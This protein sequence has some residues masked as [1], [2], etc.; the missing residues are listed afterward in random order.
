MTNWRVDPINGNDS[1][2][3]D[4]WTLDLSG[5]DGQTYGTTTFTTATGGLT[6]MADRWI[7][8]ASTLRYIVSVE[9][10]TSCTLDATY[11]SGSGRSFWIGGPFQNCTLASTSA[12][13]GDV[14]RYPKTSDPQE[15]DD[16]T[17]TNFDEDVTIP[18][19]HVQLVEDCEAGW[20]QSTDITVTHAAT[21]KVCGTN[22]LRIAPATGFTTGKMAY[23]DFGV[24]NEL[25]LSSFQGLSLFFGAANYANWTGGIVKI[26]LCS[27]ATGDTVVDEIDI[28]LYGLYYNSTNSRGYVNGMKT[29]GG[30]LG[31]SIRSIAI[32]ATTDP[33]TYYYYFDNIVAIKSLSDT[34]HLCHSCLLSLGT[35]I[36][37]M[38]YS[39]QCFPDDTTATLAAQYYGEVTGS[40]TTYT[41]EAVLMPEVQLVGFTT[42]G[43][44]DLRYEFSGGWDT[45]TDTQNGITCYQP[46]PGNQ[47]TTHCV[48][49]CSYGWVKFSNFITFG[50]FAATGTWRDLYTFEN[51]AGAPVAASS[52]PYFIG[53]STTTT[54]QADCHDFLFKGLRLFGYTYY[55]IYGSPNAL[56]D[57]FRNYFCDW[58]WEDI[59]LWSCMG[60]LL[61]DAL[62]TVM[63]DIEIMNPYTGYTT[64]RGL[65]F[66]R[67]CGETDIYNLTI[68][69][70]SRY[71]IETSYHQYNT[72][73]WNLVTS[74]ST[75][76]AIYVGASHFQ[77]F[78]ADISEGTPYVD[79]LRGGMVTSIKDGGVADT[80]VITTYLGTIESDQTVRHTASGVSWKFSPTNSEEEPVRMKLGAIAAEQG[81]ETTFSVY[82][83]RT[84]TSIAG[85]LWIEGGQVSGV[86]SVVDDSISVAADIWELLSLVFTPTETGVV[87]VWYETWGGTTENTWLDDV[88]IVTA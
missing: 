58:R 19:G 20:V 72:R 59:K 34:D 12:A 85:R 15:C 66:S 71:A 51:L 46:W 17:Y 75:L 67:G 3:G 55:P 23:Y 13:P 9:S 36:D 14:F 49:S 8:I 54:V 35:T 70:S 39:V 68:K 16:F 87:E 86:A 7:R 38:H 81:V 37:D 31:S 24:G 78:N 18:S 5:T 69:Y 32:Y 22:A 64:Q 25:D 45:S 29:G 80:H 48:F 2:S 82:A 33:N 57:T 27:D 74:D 79:I 47:N 65:V 63:R 43:T 60:L 53:I 50:T 30:N 83:R 42:P 21:N 84:D 4:S 1:Y 76:G 73:I 10:D 52:S 26:C 44:H 28:D 88:S 11:T 61:T 41:R 77:L 56:N 62:R 6:G 40:Q